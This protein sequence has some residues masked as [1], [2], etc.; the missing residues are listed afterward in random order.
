LTGLCA[1][2]T[3]R[4]MGF[5]LKIAIF[6]F[7]AWSI[8]KAANR[9]FDLLGGNRRPAAPPTP[10][11][12]EPAPSRPPLVEDTRPCSVCGTYIAVSAARCGRPDCPQ[13]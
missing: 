7:V 6:G 8:W 3:T 2:R 9:W 12:R 4:D 10:P 13:P 11:P 5:L 1:R